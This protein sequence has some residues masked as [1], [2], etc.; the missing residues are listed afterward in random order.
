MA[1]LQWLEDH[2]RQGSG[3]W[4]EQSHICMQI[5][6]EEQWGS[7]TTQPR[8]LARGNKPQNLLTEKN[9]AGCGGGMN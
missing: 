4:S 1:R 7:K 6:Q 2:G 5:N 3:W 8:V 9:C